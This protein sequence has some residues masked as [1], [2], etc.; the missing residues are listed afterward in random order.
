MADDTSRLT[1][2][3]AVDAS[4]EPE[5]FIR[6][7]EAT[8]ALPD[9][10][11]RRR[12]SYELLEVV[13]GH[14]ATDV[15]CGLGTA[16][17]ELAEAVGP[18]GRV[19]GI[20]NSATMIELAR[21]RVADATLPLVFEVAEATGLPLADVSVD[22]Y[23]AERLYQHLPDVPGA[24]VEARRVLRPGGHL[25]LVDQDWETFLVDADERDTTRQ[26]LNHFCD[27]I[28]NGWI[29]RQYRRLL[30]DAE[31]ADVDVLPDTQLYTDF[32]FWEP[33]LGQMVGPAV[34]DGVVG[35]EEAAAWLAD[36]RRRAAEG[37]FLVSMTHFLAA[38]R[39]A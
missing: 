30:D 37:R 4:A 22:G 39:R 7:L 20:D 18:S 21:G 6:F 33:L 8:D 3:G 36:Q 12:R 38:A 16:A 9:V 31:F 29:G 17:V 34:E 1:R 13:E 25:V 2:F 27:S 26:L 19:V 28:R 14:A 35:A 10:R 5:Q 11:A 32:G 24:L 23:R 15:G